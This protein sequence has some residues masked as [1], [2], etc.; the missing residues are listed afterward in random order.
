MSSPL[1]SKF[2]VSRPSRNPK[3]P[4]ARKHFAEPARDQK[5]S[6]QASRNLKKS[7]CQTQHKLGCPRPPQIKK[8]AHQVAKQRL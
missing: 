8:M 3:N 2:H 1:V 4:S 7:F 5:Y 6:C